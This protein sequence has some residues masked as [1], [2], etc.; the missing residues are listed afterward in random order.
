MR[1][2]P[3]LPAVSLSCVLLTLP[4]CRLNQAISSEEVSYPAVY[5]TP[6]ESKAGTLL[7]TDYGV[8]CVQK[9]GSYQIDPSLAGVYMRATGAAEA[10]RLLAAPASAAWDPTGSRIVVNGGSGVAA[11]DTLGNELWSIPTTSATL[12]PSWSADG[13][14]VA[15]E[16][17][18]Q[19]GG[20]FVAA[21]DSLIP[22]RVFAIA[23]QTSWGPVD[24]R[25]YTAISSGHGSL[26]VRIDP[27]TAEADTIAKLGFYPYGVCVCPDNAA[28]ISAG[29]VDGEDLSQLFRTNLANGST[30]RL[31]SEG[32]SEPS[33]GGDGTSVLFIAENPY[34]FRSDLNT[35]WKLSLRRARARRDLA[36]YEI[37]RRHP[38]NR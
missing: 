14:Y 23:A 16:Q 26:L 15:W 8:I 18:F 7:Y 12:Q 36:A 30:I 22:R 9:D 31:T 37:V 29:E 38:C 5:G 3:W 21:V 33:M 27:A 2:L 17:L 28:V 24:H 6:S 34:S 1:P 20:I 10:R 11:F 13:R 19:S 35:T 32:A 25:I 4:S